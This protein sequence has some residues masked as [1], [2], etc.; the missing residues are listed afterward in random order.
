VDER[1]HQAEAIKQ[2]VNVDLDRDVNGHPYLVNAG[3]T[4][5]Q[6]GL[7]AERKRH[8]RVLYGGTVRVVGANSVMV[9]P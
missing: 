7:K 2:R 1:R 9:R 5:K 6:L 4:Q 3:D 8:L